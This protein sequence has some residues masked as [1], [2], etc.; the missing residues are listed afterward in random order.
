MKRQ[1]LA[2]VVI[3]LI[4]IQIF[5]IN[6]AYSAVNDSSKMDAVLVLDVSGSMTKSDPKSISFEAANM[7]IDMCSVQGDRVG[8]VA[9]ND[10]IV[11]QIPMKEINSAADKSQLKNAISTLPKKSATDI[12]LGLKTAVEMLDTSHDPSR[13]PLIIFLSDGKNELGSSRTK[14]QS[15]TDKKE[16][17]QIA[18]YK[19]YKVYTIGLNADG[20]VDQDEL[21]QIS[22]STGAKN[23][24]TDTPDNLPQILSEIFADNLQ[25]KIV[26]PGYINGTGDYQNVKITIPDNN[27]VEANISLLSNNP[28]EV[29]L[30]D[31]KG[32]EQ[33]IPSKNILYSTSHSYSMIKILNPNKGDWT[34]KV[35]GISGDRIKVNLIFNYNLQLVMDLSKKDKFNK[36]D[37]I[38]VTAYLQSNGQK[39]QGADSYS[40]LK[41][42][43]IVKDLDKQTEQTI[44]MTSSADGF[45]GSFTLGD[46]K[47]YEVKVTAE[48]SSFLKESESYAINIDNRAVVISQTVGDIQI[49]DGGSS[50]IDLSK[51]FYDPDGDA[52]TYKVSS[53]PGDAAALSINGSMLDIKPQKGGS[54]VVTLSA[55][56]GRGGAVSTTFKVSFVSIIPYIIG[57]ILLILLLVFLLAVLP[58]IKKRKRPLVGQLAIEV[59]DLNTNKASTPQYRRLDTYRGRVSL[60]QL[61]QLLP[62][63]KEGEKIIFTRGKN[64]TLILKNMTG[65]TVE[66]TG[67][68]IDTSKGYTFRFG[69]RFNINLSSS[70]KSVSVEYFN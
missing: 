9:Y 43:I 5:S 24:I 67:R 10:K 51:V 12:G 3:L 27:V 26:S 62:E 15:D 34:L 42:R 70:Q 60:Y 11:Q 46:S 4:I 48:A 55:D 32:V 61:L 35:K 7:F 37:N 25:L 53:A 20:S 19:G 28:V 58:Y 45:K 8:V 65:S 68:L 18:S 23:F 64:D 36:G 30:I 44:D 6:T 63:F 39:L 66:K 13:K 22:S 59:R 69:D 14:E 1:R 31:N 38:D 40:D 50:Q 47:K 16:A 29:K 21:R 33:S 49:F 2:I 56:D 57:G 54:T 41:G 17:L 52:I